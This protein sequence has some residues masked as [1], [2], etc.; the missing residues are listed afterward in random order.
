MASGICEC[1]LALFCY[2]E[3]WLRNPAF[4]DGDA[5]FFLGVVG[6]C[7]VDVEPALVDGLLEEGD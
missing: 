1:C 6:I 3:T 2:E 7:T 4:F 5:D